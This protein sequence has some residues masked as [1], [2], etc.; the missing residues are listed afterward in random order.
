MADNNFEQYQPKVCDTAP[1]PPPLKKLCNACTPNKSFIPP[2]WRKQIDEPFLNEAQCEYQVGVTMNRDA[3]S[4]T[5]AEFRN[6]IG[7]GKKYSTR[8]QFLFSFVQPAIVLIL[9]E[10]DKLVA[11]QI[12]CASHDGPT[13]SGLMPNELIAKYGTFEGIFMD[14]KDDPVTKMSSCPDIFRAV[15]TERIHD[16]EQPLDMAQFVL[17]N[18]RAEV[19]NPFALELYARAVDFDIDPIQNLV[20]VLVTIPSF[21]IDQVPNNPTAED[22]LQEAAKT[23]KEVELDVQKLFGQITRHRS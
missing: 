3:K 6:A 17:R 20:K 21:I 13:V 14:L 4:F 2:D 23:K 8:E 19:K 5:A 22:I 7:E 9:E 15:K 11:N 10:L 1:E 12:I 18:R 16:P